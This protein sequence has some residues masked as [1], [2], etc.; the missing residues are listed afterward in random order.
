MGIL[1]VGAGSM[2]IAYASVL[3]SLN[4][5][6]DVFTRSE[7]TALQFEKNTEKKAYFGELPS[8]LQNNHYKKAIVAIDVAYLKDVTKILLAHGMKEVLI[9]KPGAMNEAELQDLQ[10]AANSVKAGVWIGYN[11]RFYDSVQTLQTFI[12]EDN[13]I[14]SIHFTFTELSKR[15]EQLHNSDELKSN[16]LFANSSHVIDLAFYLAGQPT[17]F[18][19]FTSDALPWHPDGAIFSGAGVTEKA[20]LFSYHANW[21]APGRWGVEVMTD[22]YTFIL[23]PLEK[24]YKMEHGSFQLQ[25][26]PLQ[27]TDDVTFKPGLFKQVQAFL[28]T[29]N[30]L[31]TVEEQL[32]HAQT[33]YEKIK[34][35]H[36]SSS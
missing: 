17:S 31:I 13:P 18:H 35:G 1:L 27:G 22:D 7:N 25:E 9:E 14:K 16:W 5:S 15:I 29:K 23:Q 28:T 26:V 36:Q 11:R 32:L 30:G 10:Q 12:T 33:I 19:A 20:V 6:F 24:L 4:V 3:K 8:L 2:G 34:K 21:K